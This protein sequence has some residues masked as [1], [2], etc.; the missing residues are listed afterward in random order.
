MNK[1][2]K[3]CRETAVYPDALTDSNKELTHLTLGLCGEAGEVA[4]KVKRIERR[5]LMLFRTTEDCRDIAEELGDTLWYL[6]RLAD[7]LG[8]DLDD[9]MSQNLKKTQ[10][11]YMETGGVPW[12][13][14]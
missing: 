1:Y 12:E 3:K 2:Q 10:K 11:R 13:K 8:F 14:H 7:A 4:N 6:A 9:I 5:Q